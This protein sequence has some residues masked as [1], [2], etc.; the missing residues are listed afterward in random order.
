MLTKRIVKESGD[1]AKKRQKYLPM[2]DDKGIAVSS[3]NTKTGNILSFSI[4]PKITC[5][6]SAQCFEICYAV[7]MYNNEYRKNTP[8]S[9]ERNLKILEETPQKAIH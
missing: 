4:P 1:F 2:I 9:W 7:G 3:S 6:N 5:P 8:I